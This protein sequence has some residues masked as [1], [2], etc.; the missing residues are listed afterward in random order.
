VTEQSPERRRAAATLTG[1]ALVVFASQ[2]FWVH[3]AGAQ[4]PVWDQWFA[5]FGRVYEP[6]MRGALPFDALAFV[7]NEHHLLTSRLISILLFLTSG[8]WDVKGEMVALAA[9]RGTEMALLFMLLS[10]LI[11]ERRRVVLIALV[12][13]VGA[14]PLSPLNVLS[15]IQ[16]QFRLVETFSILAL[17]VAVKPADVERVCALVLLLLL[18]FL[19]MATGIVAM[20]AAAVIILAQGLAARTL[21]RSRAAVAGL[22]LGLAA[23]ALFLT[24]RYPQYGPSSAWESLRILVRCLSFPFPVVSGWAVLSHVPVAILAFLLF[25][26]RAAQD[27][28]WLVV[29]LA[30]WT[31]MLT[32]AL[33]LGRGATAAPGEQHLEFLAFPLIWNYLALVRVADT[34]ARP[35]S[36][37]R[38]VRLSPS[39]WAL[40][41]CTFLAGHA[42]IRA[43][44][45]LREMEVAR[46]LV[47]AR[48]RQSLLTQDFR[49]E[50]AEALKA[51]GLL[52]AGDASFLLYDPIG[53]YTIPQYAVQ[54]LARRDPPLGRLFP[55]ALSGIGRPALSARFLEGTAAAWPFALGIGLGLLFLGLRPSWPGGGRP[56][57]AR[58]Q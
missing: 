37:S 11:A 35:G 26:T 24:P 1:L 38:L 36:V 4:V 57:P 22:L 9:V 32:L 52:R 58:V 41:A 47:E 12:L 28:A 44:P 6:L 8:Y 23:F 13:A 40:A 51:E 54:R 42:W 55:P 20:L 48:F 2:C 50:S 10:P 56:S 19:S 53:R 3:R 39:L 21:P 46:P 15:G 17:A 7:H 16:A 45:E 49:R 30:T 29:A 34:P 14:L 25:R 33:A 27:R 43:V 31:L 5:E 18:A